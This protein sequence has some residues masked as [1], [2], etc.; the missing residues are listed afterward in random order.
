MF[1]LIGLVAYRFYLVLPSFIKLLLV[2]LLLG[3]VVFR[4]GGFV[5]C[6][7]RWGFLVFPLGYASVFKVLVFRVYGVL[8]GFLGG[9][10]FL[11]VG[12][13]V[14]DSC[15]YALR[16][17]ASRVVAVEPDP[18][19]A[20]LL[21][22]NLLVNGF[23]GFGVVEACAGGLCAL[24]D[25]AH[26]RVRRFRGSAVRW[27]YLLQ[28]GFDVVKVDCE[29]CEW[30]LEGRHISMAPVWLIEVM[31]SLER[32]LSRV[33]PGYEVEVVS[34]GL[35][36]ASLRPTYLLLVYDRRLRGPESRGRRWGSMWIQGLQRNSL[37]RPPGS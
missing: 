33:P 26:G 27:D 24:V 25:W 14:G 21:R 23:R 31:G 9:S 32:F 16:L 34:R 19:M 11:D 37:G 12:A 28:Q 5:G 18:L 7:S 8:D 13:G 1:G 2:S 17:G 36:S 20:R 15:L 10:R 30:T 29:G 4:G 22:F 6:R 3:V 35:D